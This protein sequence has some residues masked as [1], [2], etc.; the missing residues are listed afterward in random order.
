MNGT[1]RTMNFKKDQSE[2]DTIKTGGF[3]DQKL[4]E[5]VHDEYED[6]FE[7]IEDL[8]NIDNFEIGYG[9][10]ESY[11]LTAKPGKGDLDNVVN[12]YKRFITKPKEYQMA[13]SSHFS[14]LQSRLCSW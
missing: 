9:D 14:E 11:R 10:D 6:E 2:F 3:Y 5:K 12:E 7:D 4:H 8:T 13:N 1:K